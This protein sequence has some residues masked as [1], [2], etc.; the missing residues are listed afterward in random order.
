MEAATLHKAG[1]FDEAGRIY[2]E[3]IEANP[4]DP[5]LWHFKGL[6]AA[7]KGNFE[8]AVRFVS[9]AIT[10]KP[11]MPDYYQTLAMSYEAL[12]QTSKA[13]ETY[14]KFANALQEQCRFAEAVPAYTY[15][16]QLSPDLASVMI[17]RGAALARMGRHDEAAVDFTTALERLGDPSDTANLLNVA[18]AL[19]GLGRIEEAIAAYTRLLAVDPDHATAHCSR[20]LLSLRLGRMET[21]WQEYDWRWSR[22][23]GFREPR[24]Q[25]RQKVWQGESP[26][27]LGGALLVIAEQGLGD[28]IQFARYIPLLADQGYDII[29]ETLPE[30]TTLFAEGFDHPHIRVIERIDNPVEIAG[31]LPFAAWV[32]VMSL[33][34]RFHT[35][36][37]T[38]PAHV[39]YLKVTPEKIAAWRAKLNAPGFKVGLVWAGNPKN[40]NDFARSI[41]APLLEPLLSTPH[42]AFYSLQKGQSETYEFRN[43]TVARLAPALT[44]LTQAAAAIEALDLLITVDTSLCHLAGA[45]GRPV[46]LMIPVQPDWR[47]LEQGDT[48]PWYPTMRIFRQTIRGKWEDVIESVADALEEIVKQA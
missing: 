40:L 2:Q 1:K 35:V 27:D 10:L 17:N 13:A 30:L 48:S 38:I 9:L 11:A 12:G 37:E 3:L 14:N 44:D 32:G 36:L 22:I 41:P 43:D 31:N 24:G 19:S 4:N 34:A 33:P 5:D 45:L 42:V 25:F 23:G 18:N 28:V 47:W 15:S 26:Q 39:P 29:F 8:E 16:L 46:W 21:A 20:A 7:H 6:L